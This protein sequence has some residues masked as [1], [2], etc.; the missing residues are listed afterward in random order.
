MSKR[1]ATE[2]QSASTTT[3]NEPRKTPRASG[4]KPEKT[5]DEGM[6]EFEDGWEDE[7]ESD[8][9]IVEGKDGENEGTSRSV[10]MINTY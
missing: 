1:T 7:F 6:G 3:D 2:L 9:E 5:H 4:S 10:T 8:E